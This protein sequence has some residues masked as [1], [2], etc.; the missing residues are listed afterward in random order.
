[1]LV[2]ISLRSEVLVQLHHSKPPGF[3]L[4]G[5]T[6]LG[7]LD[8]PYELLLCHGLRQAKMKKRGEKRKGG[9]VG[10]SLSP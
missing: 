6:T 4:M 2:L 3:D 8:V 7:A 10:S 5:I 1:M 9:G